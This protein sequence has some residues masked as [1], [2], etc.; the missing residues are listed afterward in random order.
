[1]I[2]NYGYDI[3]TWIIYEKLISLIIFNL[4]NV[5]TIKLTK[6]VANGQTVIKPNHNTNTSAIGVC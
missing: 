1:M 2:S 3:N 4:K 5:I 6:M